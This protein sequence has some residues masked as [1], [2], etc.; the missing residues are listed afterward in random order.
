MI[1]ED[2][3]RQLPRSGLLEQSHAPNSESCF[4]IG[5]FESFRGV[6]RNIESTTYSHQLSLLVMRR[7]LV[8]IKL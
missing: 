2:T 6:F 3:A 1:F 8:V 5:D 7:P 4:L